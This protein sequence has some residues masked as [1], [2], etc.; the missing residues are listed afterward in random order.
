MIRYLLSHPDKILNPLLVHIELVVITLVLS[1]I[2]A[3]LF[4]IVAVL[5]RKAGQVLLHLFSI[6][7]S[8]PS[9][10][11]FALLIP[12]TGLGKTSAVIVLV[13]YNQFLLLRNIL[14]GI[15]EVDPAVVDAAF[16]IGFTKMQV[17][18]KI[19][20]PLARNAIV[21]GI[22]ISAVSTI[23]IATIAS[24]INAGGL[25]DLLF[26]GLRTMNIIKIVWGS[27][28]AAGLSVLIDAVMKRIV[29]ESK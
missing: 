8:V 9:L 12:L 20:L 28:L 7:Y 4:T 23:G 11:L 14:T 17:L 1:V 24:S 29:P 10:A 15:E 27:I 26:D 22:R 21:S 19:Q 6:I 18:R 2:L 5:N 16:G 3:F 25:G 13:I